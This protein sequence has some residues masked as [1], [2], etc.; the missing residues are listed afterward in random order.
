[1]L[2]YPQLG[3]VAVCGASIIS[4]ETVVDISTTSFVV[5]L[6]ISGRINFHSRSAWR[7]FDQHIGFC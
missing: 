6:F 4:I 7:P 5:K 1:M 3:L 2:A